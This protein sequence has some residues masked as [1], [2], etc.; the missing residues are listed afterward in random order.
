[1]FIVTYT[2]L[3]LIHMQATTLYVHDANNR[4]LRINEADSEV[5]A[6]R[7]FLARTLSGNIWRIR[8][9]LP[10]DLAAE[11]ERLAAAEPVVHDLH[12]PPHHRAQYTQLLERHA[13]LTN[14]YEGPAYVLPEL[15]PPT[16]TVTITPQNKTL[17][18]ANFPYTMNNLENRAPVVVVVEDDVAVAACYSARLT[19]Q[20]AEAGV[21]TLENYRGRGYGAET[22][23]GWAQELR[24]S[25]RTPLYSTSWDNLASQAVALKLGASQYG[26]EFS[27][28]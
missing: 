7:F 22:V 23:R 11:L 16:K 8:Y 24:A 28:T 26:V 10:D 20:V 19:T 4:L 6:P 18:Q 12:R 1:M 13:P 2:D 15:D 17:L 5:P 25:G 21:H 3:E 27:V 14:V 9:D